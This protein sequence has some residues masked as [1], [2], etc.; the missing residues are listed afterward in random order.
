MKKTL[1]II[2]VLLSLTMLFSCNTT[3]K[4][5]DKDDVEKTDLASNKAQKIANSYTVVTLNN[6]KLKSDN[7]TLIFNL[8]K[9]KL[10]GNTGCNQYGGNITIDGDKIKLD[11]LMATKMYCADKADIE[12]AFTGALA[13]SHHFKVKKN[14]FFLYDKANNVL[15]IGEEKE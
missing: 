9:N 1:N 10:N 12:R 7:P 4:S 3:K 11:R 5:S 2:F 8:E 14:Q 13:K 15:L 6:E